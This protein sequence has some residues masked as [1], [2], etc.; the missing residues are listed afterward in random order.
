[1]R[2]RRMKEKGSWEMGERERDIYTPKLGA[3]Q[4]GFGTW[5]EAWGARTRHMREGR[6]GEEGIR[7][8]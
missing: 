2:K 6:G 7:R 3:S 5:K 4:L 8:S 1:M